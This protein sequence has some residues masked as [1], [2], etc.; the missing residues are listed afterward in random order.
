[1]TRQRYD[2]THVADVIVLGFGGAGGCAAIEAHDCG[3]DVI[4]IE[5]QPGERHY[6]NTRMSGGGYHSPSRDGDFEA[7]KAY[8][9]A[10][11]SGENLPQ[12]LEGE[13][14]DFSDEL[15]D[16]WARYSPENE[17]FMRSLDPDYK[18]VI[19]SNAAFPDFP[20]AGNSGYAVV[21]STYTGSEDEAELFRFT[22]DADK[23]QKQSGEAFHACLLTGVKSR[24]IP[25]HYGTRGRELL[26][27]ED[28]EVTGLVCERDGRRIAYRARRGVVLTCG[29]YE[30]NKRMR[31]AF[32]EGPGVEGWAFYGTTENTG[33]G[34]EMALKIGAALT[35]VG[36]IA[37]RVICAVPVRRH[38]LKIGLN[39]NG[40]G[41]PNE[42][43]VDSYGNRYA[44][45]RRIT[46]D[47]SRY[48]FYKEALQFDTINLNYPRIPSWMVFDTTL[49]EAGPIV[50]VA[51]AAYNAIDWGHDNTN[52]VRQGWILKG[53]T[54]EELARRIAEHPDNRGLMQ[55]DRLAQTVER[56][57]GFCAEG[58][59]AD[60]DRE[61]KTMAPVE[62][63]PFYAIPL[64]PGGPNTK[65]G[66]RSNARRQVLDWE[67]RPIPRLF[68]AG[69]I[70]SAF[71][72]VYQG[73]GNLA[74]CITFGRLAGREAASQPPLDGP[75]RPAGAKTHGRVAEP[76]R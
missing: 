34:I 61:P 46:K 12:M 55:P 38:G 65:G 37:G 51:A 24:G 36:K 62:K 69:E 16:A 64:Y 76:V 60:F 52:A 48:I 22:V 6:S 50:R 7:L 63:A 75:D 23:K 54:I 2:E 53:E 3:A 14:P 70:S 72:F 21:K 41:K 74:E 71:Q 31:K 8:A 25:V 20:G 47:P 68:T 26:I 43:V 29:G 59:D 27:N 73:G 28:G 33:D 4:L 15:A 5:R 32:L 56:F 1:M 49:I 40:V 19:I 18:T 39:T 10:M 13:Q 45:E 11:F 58:H 30:Y 66:L 17:S 35:K 57:N 44:S 42:I 67:D 9:K